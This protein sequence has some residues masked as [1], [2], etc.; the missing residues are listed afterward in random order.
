M[1]LRS[2]GT[3]GAGTACWWATA[4]KDLSSA[5]GSEED[6]QAAAKE[7]NAVNAQFQATAQEF[8]L[9]QTA[10]STAIKSLGEG[11]SAMARKQ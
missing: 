5:G 7:V 6:Q 4:L 3:A 10:F 1:P 9:L 11:L 2:T 8:N